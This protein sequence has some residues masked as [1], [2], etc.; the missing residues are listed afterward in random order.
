MMLKYPTRASPT[1]LLASKAHNY[2]LLHRPAMFEYRLGRTA[3]PRHLS[4]GWAERLLLAWVQAG[5]D[6]YSSPEFRLGRMATPRLSRLGRMATPR[7]SSGWA[8]WLL[9]AWVQ[10]GPDGYSSAKFRLGRMASLCLSQWHS[11]AAMPSNA[12]ASVFCSVAEFSSGLSLKAM[13]DDLPWLERT[14]EG[15]RQSDEHFCTLS[16]SAT[17]YILGYL[18]Y[19]L[20]RRTLYDLERFPH[21]FIF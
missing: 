2:S 5:P 11:R 14:R 4:S 13:H 8:G 16:A 18:Q 1:G 17:I 7:L 3:T 6:G 12:R 20:S 9:L 15:H 10:T 19:S 21:L